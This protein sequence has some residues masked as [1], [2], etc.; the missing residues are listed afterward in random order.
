[1]G[2]KIGAAACF[3]KYGSYGGDPEYR[4]KKWYEWWER[5]GKYQKRKMFLSKEIR[6][7]KYS[8]NLAEFV[9]IILGD[10]G[11][12]KYQVTVSLHKYDDKE[13]SKFVVQLFK[14]LFSVSASIVCKKNQRIKA[15]DCLVSRKK[16][17]DYCVNTLG[18]KIGNKVKQQVDVPDWVKKKL[19]YKISCLRGLIDTDGSIFLH[20]YKVNGKEY[21]Y[22]KITF[23]NSSKPLVKYVNSILCEV[24][25][26]SRITRQGK[27][28][29][30]GSI[31]DIK[32]YFR[33]IG[34]HNPKH[35]K[36]YK[37]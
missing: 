14:K 13:Y 36:R 17:V 21:K 27:E 16:L 4:K 18:L 20:R 12:T 5:E 37:K 11:I 9:G 3:K 24:G 28:V 31:V 35:L 7:P 8:N 6:K 32:K 10:G 26:N 15:I 23:N 2:G 19:S 34:S 25:I 33:V 1:M 22:K 30:I 29:R